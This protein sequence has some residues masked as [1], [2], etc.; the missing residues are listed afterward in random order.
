ML[1]IITPLYEIYNYN[2]ALYG[3]AKPTVLING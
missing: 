2:A 3:T 1:N